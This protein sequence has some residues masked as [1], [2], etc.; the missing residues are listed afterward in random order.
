MSSSWLR[1]AAVGVVAALVC[2][3]AL[4]AALAQ[5]TT[6]SVQG[7]VLDESKA[8]VPGATLEL[9]N[10]A[11]N[12]VRTQVSDPQGRYLFNF[13]P[14]GTYDLRATLSGFKAR[15]VSGLGVVV[16]KNIVVDLTLQPGG[17]EE[18]VDVTA[19]TDFI[20]TKSAAVGTNVSTRQILELPSSSA[21]SS[22]RPSSPPASPSTRPPSPR[23]ARSSAS[24]ARPPT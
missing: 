15:E 10:V 21:T 8:A 7:T 17:I 16:A 24:T 1:R 3:G 9:R 22:P 11:T 23:G 19:S 4:P 13:V 5:Q 20:E 18:T 2:V 14:P 6:G 12:V